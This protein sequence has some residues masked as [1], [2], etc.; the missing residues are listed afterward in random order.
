[1][2]LSKPEIIENIK[3]ESGNNLFDLVECRV[4]TENQYNVYIFTLVLEDEEKLIANWKDIC[5]EIAIYF[6]GELEKEIEI[7][8]IYV[9]FLIG[10][11]VNSQTRYSI[12]QNKYSS[13]KLVIENVNRPL[14]I[15][16]IEGI[17]NEKLFN[18]NVNL[19]S[20]QSS[21]SEPISKTLETKYGNLFNVI[22]NNGKEKP[23]VLL[24]KYLELLRNEF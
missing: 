5:G 6:Q 22:K 21:V 14:G 24:T 10:S 13:R 16:K 11:S 18:L 7:W 9:L 2:F 12:E 3:K 1:M 17:I 19:P 15:E 4:K 20:S 23:S 8:N